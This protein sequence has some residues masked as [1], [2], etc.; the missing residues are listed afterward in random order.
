MHVFCGI[1]F[2]FFYF[3]PVPLAV[4][5]GHS[6]NVHCNVNL[7]IGFVEVAQVGLHSSLPAALVLFAAVGSRCATHS[8]TASDYPCSPIK[9]SLVKVVLL[10]WPLGSACTIWVCI[11][12]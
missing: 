3:G 5:N 9:Q 8:S 4:H 6:S 11:R 7:T 1:D 2:L 12:L 10:H